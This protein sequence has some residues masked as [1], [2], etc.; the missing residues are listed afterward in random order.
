[1][2]PVEPEVAVATRYAG[3]W[4]EINARLQSRQ[5]VLV[6][7]ATIALP[8]VSLAVAESIKADWFAWLTLSL[9]ALGLVFS[10]WVCHNDLIIGLLS[11]FCR[12]CES[13]QYKHSGYPVRSVPSWFSSTQGWMDAALRY[14]Q[15]SDLG[16]IIV[17]LATCIPAAMATHEKLMNGKGWEAVVALILTFCGLVGGWLTSSNGRRRKRYLRT[18]RLVKEA[19]GSITLKCE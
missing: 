7:Y 9:P 11:V 6:T 2:A 16:F 10:L 15:F 12:E 1:M 4:N 13:E 18:A 8:T 5:R 19:D 17:L 14:R 3:A